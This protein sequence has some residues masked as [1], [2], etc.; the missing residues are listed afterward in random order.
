MY[1]RLFRKALCVVLVFS[2]FGCSNNYVLNLYSKPS[3]VRVNVGPKVEGRTPC[4]IEIPKKSDLIKDHFI[5]VTYTLEDGTEIVKS[6]DMRNYE[7]PGEIPMF[8]GAIFAAPGALLTWFSLPEDTN[9]DSFSD[10]DNDPYWP[11]VGIGIG[12]MCVGVLTYYV[13]GGKPNPEFE[14]DINETFDN[15]N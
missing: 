4:K 10:E 15:V 3:G 11:G 13:L 5:D 9:E 8:G 14:Y 12:L 1:R 7:P 2:L 6:Y